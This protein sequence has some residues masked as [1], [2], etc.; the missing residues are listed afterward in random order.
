MRKWGNR[1]FH[2]L[3]GCIFFLQLIQTF[4]FSVSEFFWKS[5]RLWKRYH[6]FLFKTNPSRPLVLLWIEPPGPWSRDSW[7]LVSSL[8]V[9]SPSQIVCQKPSAAFEP[10]ISSSLILVSFFWSLLWSD[11]GFT[12][13]FSYSSRCLLCYRASRS[14]LESRIAI[15]FFWIFRDFPDGRMKNVFIQILKNSSIECGPGL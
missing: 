4:K 1:I 9:Y 10:P 8:L 11:R 5:N 2:I 7:S 13:S 14:G 6:S 3:I 12:R 15:F